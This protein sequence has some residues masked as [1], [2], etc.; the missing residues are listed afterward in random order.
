M[1]I[2]VDAM[3][4]DFAP[5]E[6]VKGACQARD[7][8]G[9]NIT[10]V[11]C[12]EKIREIALEN[13]LSL[14][15][16]EIVNTTEVV[17]MDDHPLA[18]RDKLDSSMRVAFKM[19][20][21]GEGDALVS[22]GNTG[23]LHAGSTLI[24]HRVRGVLRSAIAT[25]LPL[26]KPVLLI[27]SG[28]NTTVTEEH[29]VQFAVMGSLYMEK[30]F[31]IERPKVGLVNIG[32]EEIKGTPLHVETYKKLKAC[33]EINFYG[34]IEGKE[35]PFSPCDVLLADGF[36]GNIVLKYT[37]GMGKF[38]LKTLKGLFTQ[39]TATKVAALAMKKQL[40]EMKRQFDA[41]EYGGAPLLGISKPV[42]KAHGSSDAKALKNA[43]VQ[44]IAFIQTGMNYDIAGVAAELD[45]KREAA[46]AAA[47]EAKN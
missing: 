18:V 24:V 34:N 10:L 1:N 29:L 28:A 47:K 4:G 15:N 12:E 42:I 31:N 33:E 13:N 37:E 38:L 19:L 8:L 21:H 20:K 36:T 45:A 16:I 23:A 30:V 32:S 9:I 25:V 17:E 41:S 39:N 46:K 7:E 26:E 3:G 11:G 2:I 6:P 22:A 40:T 35:I 14:E 5:L 43:V 44:A 27:D